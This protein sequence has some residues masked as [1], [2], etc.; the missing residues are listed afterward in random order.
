MIRHIEVCV[1]AHNEEDF[2]VSCLE[3]IEVAL[4]NMPESIAFKV[5][6][7]NN[8][9][10]DSS[11]SIIDSFCS[12]RDDFDAKHIRLGD[13][14]N[15]W[16]VAIYELVQ[17]SESLIVMVD[18]DCTISA[19]SLVALL[20]GAKLNTDA[21]LLAAIPEPIGRYSESIT[22][23][24]LNGKALS[25]NFYAITPLFYE[26]IKQ[27]GFMLPVGLIGDDSLLAW[28]AQCDFKLSNGV[29]NGLMVGIKGALFGYHRLVPNTFKNIKMYWRRLQRY[30]LRHIQQNCIK[31]YL[32]LE[33]DDFASLPS[34]VVELYRYHRP[35]HIRTD[36]RLNTFL[37]TR[38][39]K[40][41]KTISVEK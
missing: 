4:A 26:K 15:A 7:V 32:T 23:N 19:D 21:Y 17:N 3:S 6:I 20:E 36:N 35:E 16:N 8:G 22:R 13:K 2:I 38:T 18:G 25:G 39:S 28:V 27:T 10:S 5:H 31:A 30:S 24:T 33:N 9:S 37:D 11:E 40:Q 41:I 12:T 14:S 29:K 34:H 1:V